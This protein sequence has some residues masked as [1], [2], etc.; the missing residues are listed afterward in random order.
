VV[1]YCNPIS[2]VLPVQSL[3]LDLIKALCML[4]LGKTFT[5]EKSYFLVSKATV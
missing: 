1:F 3:L 2:L 4:W 5:P